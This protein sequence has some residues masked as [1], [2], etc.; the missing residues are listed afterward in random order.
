MIEDNYKKAYTHGLE[1]IYTIETIDVKTVRRMSLPQKTDQ[2]DP[3]TSFEPIQENKESQL[4]LNLGIHWQGHMDS[5][6]LLEPIQLMGF[7]PQIERCL[8][9]N[10]VFALKELIS[11]GVDDLQHI[12]GIGQGHIIEIQEKIASRLKGRALRKC[13][14]VDF[15]A[16]LKI[17]VGSFERKKMWVLLNKFDL[18]DEICLSPLENSEIKRLNHDRRLEWEKQAFDHLH[19]EAKQQQ[20]ADCLEQ[21]SR[22]FIIPWIERRGGIASQIE[23]EERLLRMSEKPEKTEAVFHFFSHLYYHDLFPFTTLI[24]EV[25]DGLFS[26]GQAISTAYQNVCELAQTYFYRRGVSYPFE[27]LE[28]RIIL[29]FSIRWV[30]FPKGF[31]AKVLRLSPRFRLIRSSSGS[32]DIKLS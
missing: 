30:S 17:I 7:S 11:L 21:V 1:D 29:E 6:T 31:I 27:D 4:C 15:Q 12:K 25:E 19:T 32:L 23:I 13:K 28:R 3:T 5:F 26:S 24:N 10:K 14:S 2:T 22:I 16:L 20:L 18:S 8:L 9:E